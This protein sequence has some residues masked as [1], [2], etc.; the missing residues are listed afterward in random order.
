MKQVIIFGASGHGKVIAD[1]L[2]KQGTPIAGFVDDDNTKWG[3]EF[4]GYRIHGG[5]GYLA[6]TLASQVDIVVA[7]G[8]N[9]VRRKVV[10]DLQTRGFRFTTAIHPSARIGK[11]VQIGAGTVMMAGA[12]VNADTH[13][14]SHCIIN[15]ASSVGHD[16]IVG[17]FT[18]ISSGARLGGNVSVGALSWVGIGAAVINNVTIGENTIV[19]AGSVVI[20]D[21]KPHSC[22]IGNPAK[23]LK[24]FIEEREPIAIYGAGGF[25]REVAWLF[26]DMN[27][28]GKNYEVVCF[29]DD[30]ETLLGSVLNGIPVLSLDEAAK[31]F[32]GVAVVGGIGAPKVRQNLMENAAARGFRFQTFIHPTVQ[33]SQWV[34]IGSGTL[35]CAGNI[36]TTN[37]T[38]GEHVQINL[39]CTIGHDVIMGDYTTLAPG[40][41]VSGY[42][43]FGRRVYVGTGAVIIN[44][45]QE[46]P[47]VIGDDVVIGAGACVIRSV[48]A[49]LTV[50]GVPAK[51]LHR[52]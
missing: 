1:I 36:L 9:E 16:N 7:I 23:L 10:L 52:V 19:G 33:M 31:R 42:V 21:A 28:V 17:D 47:I 34:R 15:T 27:A 22:Y 4:F 6:S 5:I 41:H 35:I 46:N 49:G 14:G 39:E 8:D 25:G 30:D 48:S 18:H 37:I 3:Q 29:I 12:I 38:V 32:P 20:R 13:I 40:V 51:P 24:R 43:Y 50:G 26:E 11:N 2:E 44:G 45:T